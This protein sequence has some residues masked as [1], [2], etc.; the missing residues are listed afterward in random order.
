M[1]KDNFIEVVSPLALVARIEEMYFRQCVQHNTPDK[2]EALMFEIDNI[3]VQYASQ[4]EYELCQVCNDMKNVIIVQAREAKAQA[5]LA[6]LIK[7][8]GSITYT[9]EDFK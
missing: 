4:Q 6:I 1:N 7:E 8:C 2:V 3:R 5:E 9:A